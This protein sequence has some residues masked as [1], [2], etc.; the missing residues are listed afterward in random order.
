M[1][2]L[3]YLRVSTAEQA[4]SRAGLDAQVAAIDAE[5]QRRGWTVEYVT[6]AGYSGIKRAGRTAVRARPPGGRRGGTG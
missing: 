2:L 4:D 5:A 6:D 3:A 1:H